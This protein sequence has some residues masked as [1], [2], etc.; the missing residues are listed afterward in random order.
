VHHSEN[1]SGVDLNGVTPY[2]FTKAF[3][4]DF[5]EISQLTQLHDEGEALLTIGAERL[6][7]EKILFADSMF[8]EVFDFKVISGNPRKDLGEPGKA[9]LTKSLAEKI[10][11]DGGKTTIKIANEVEVEVVGIIEDAPK[12]SHIQFSMIV[13]MPSLNSALVGGLPL[14][15]WGLNHAGFNY[16]VLPSTVDELT[17][18]ERFKSFVKKYYPENNDNTET[19]L[20]QPLSD[21][22]FNT[23][24]ASSESMVQSVDVNNMII[25]SALGI[26]IL[27]VA[28]VNFINLAT[29]LAV[30]K[31]KEIG[32][33]KTLGAKRLQLSLAF[34][35]E[36]AII[37]L[38]ALL[39]SLGVVEWI[40]PWLSTFIEKEL[41]MNLFSNVVLLSFLSGLVIIVTLLSG[42][43]PSMI[44]SGFNPVDVLKSK[45]TT[46]RTS[47]TS[48]RKILVV[49]QFL[50][51]Q[52]L[53]IGTIIVSDQMD[54]FRNKP[55]GFAS[56]AIVNVDLPTNKQQQLDAFRSRLEANAD[57]QIVSYSMG[58][59]TSSDGLNTSLFLSEKGDTETFDVSIKVADRN[60]L[61]AYGLKLKAGRWFTESEE[62]LSSPPLKWEER[63]YVIV[64]NETAARTLGFN[65]INEIIGKKLTVG[66]NNISAP[67]IGVVADFNTKSLH[68]KISP[69]A[70]MNF[71]YFYTS[72][73]I[74]IN[75]SKL[76]ETLSFI[77]KTFT[78]IYPEYYY[79]YQ[80]LDDHLSGLY[81]QEERIFTLFKVFA[82]VSIFI[83][84]LGLYGL[85]A[86]MANQKLK[87]VGI[88]K[89]LGAS[90]ASIVM[91][92]SR[93]FVKL[94][95][96]AFIIA[97]PIAWYFMNEWLQRFAYHIDIHWSVFIIGIAITLIIALLTVG[98][99]SIRAAISN[100]TETL[101]SE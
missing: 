36:T 81:Q 44:L 6:L 75:P 70:L 66:L 43:Y 77:E 24:Y 99:R 19:Y 90:V 62:K 50:I 35:S 79:N 16:L 31:S 33:R 72:A 20:L 5:P 69:V 29:A 18:E 84:C 93:E 34:V 89:V 74:K 12:D 48:V 46:H 65:D 42:F 7:V 60:Y 56:E 14:E 63:Q 1:A 94:I 100:P 21:V 32:V 80:F 82:G 53:I 59:P 97:A 92:F 55:L 71:P 23:S 25:L 52:V 88:R 51:A 26:F 101:R 37:T 45:I 49:F 10:M 40:L 87:E 95:V 47:G 38:F 28:C 67:V 85:I 41:S 22:H 39:L 9:F 91:L 8:F 4:N 73:G 11:K 68:E 64:V 96:V 13:S 57:I 27:L 17:I 78:E 3:R 58:A 76:P 83:G 2:P 61:E 30:K 98:Y 86:F 54:Y 15:Q